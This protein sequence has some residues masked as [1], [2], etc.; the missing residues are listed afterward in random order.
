VAERN[1]A[2]SSSRIEASGGIDLANVRKYAAAGIDY[3]S[4]GS[5]TKHLHA[6]DLSLR[7]KQL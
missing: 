4:I 7:F 3:V 6:I 1:A 2:V 5:L